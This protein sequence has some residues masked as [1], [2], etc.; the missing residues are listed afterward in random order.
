MD[1]IAVLITS[2]NRK[3]KTIAC[4][5]SLYQAKSNYHQE[6]ILDVYLTDDGSTDG[7]GEA[8]RQDFPNVKILKGDGNLYWAGGMRNSWN[9]ALKNKYD[10]FLLLNDDTFVFNNLLYDIFQTEQFSIS[11]FN[12]KG[13]YIGSTKDTNN[14]KLT[15][16]GAIIENKF[17]LK[18]K[19]LNPSGSPQM[20]ELGNA[21][22][23]YVSS[24][25]IYSIGILNKNYTH[26][27]ADF[28]YTL[29]ARRHKIPVLV[30]PNYCGIC[31]NNQLDKYKLFESKS[32]FNKIKYLYEP[33][34]LKFNDNL[35]FMRRNFPYRLPFVFLSGWFK[36]VFPKTYKLVR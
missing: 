32:F 1:K 21:N 15:Y 29:T 36:V 25:S 12:K 10:G 30:T 22:I 3:S 18:Y 24:E 5:K 16:G 34:G 11:N 2:H 35:L 19:K 8:V 14:T 13:I 33:T 23:M 6:L 26:G 20:C 17:L 31:D 9:E 7:T 4:L 27:I 28:D